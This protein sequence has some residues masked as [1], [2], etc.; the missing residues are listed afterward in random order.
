MTSVRIITR[1]VD[2]HAVCQDLVEN[3]QNWAQDVRARE[4]GG[5]VGKRLKCGLGVEWGVGVGHR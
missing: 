1:E 4:V 2:P 3:S 5:I